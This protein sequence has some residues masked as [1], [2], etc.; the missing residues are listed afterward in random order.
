MAPYV[1]AI[2]NPTLRKIAVSLI[3]GHVEQ[4]I[5]RTEAQQNH[6]VCCTCGIANGFE[7]EQ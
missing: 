2:V 7:S 4:V 3:D 6:I 1:S 5:I